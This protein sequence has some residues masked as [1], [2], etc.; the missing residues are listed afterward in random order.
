MS[1]NCTECNKCKTECQCQ[2]PSVAGPMYA[3]PINSF[4]WTGN[5]LGC[6]PNNPF[7]VSGQNLQDALTNV[8]NYVCN[9]QLI[10]GPQGAD[11]A[12]GSDAFIYTG[13]TLIVSTLGDD[14]T[15]SRE[16]W[17]KHFKTIT[18]A[19][20]AS[21][22]GDIII[23]FP[24][25][26]TSNADWIKS[27][28]AYFFYDNAVLTSFGVCI[29][30]SALQ[31][32]IRI[33]GRGSFFSQT[34]S[35]VRLDNQFTSIHFEFKYLEGYT[36]VFTIVNC[37]TFYFKG[38]MI[39]PVSQYLGTIRGECEGIIDVR[40]QD[41]SSTFLQA[42]A[43]FFTN[44][45]VSGNKK[46]VKIK[47]DILKTNS[48]SSLGSIVQYYTCGLNSTI[49]YDVRK[50]QRSIAAGQE[51]LFACYFGKMVVRNCAL[52]VDT[53]LCF[54]NGGR[55]DID[56]V[57]IRCNGAFLQTFSASTVRV[58]N[59]VG[60]SNLSDVS[61]SFII[62]QNTFMDVLDNQ[63][64]VNGSFNAFTLDVGGRFAFGGNIIFMPDGSGY[65]IAATSTPII[66]NYLKDDFSNRANDP[67]VTNAITGTALLTDPLI[68]L[69]T[70]INE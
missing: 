30:D 37:S 9:I 51:P 15:A 68:D 18:A 65:C 32:D 14:N 39:R 57:S 63:F 50:T 11:G 55:L 4:V 13:K 47:G 21:L 53:E 3:F 41:A 20:A 33:Y 31:K 35:A 69:I 29:T 43:Y 26:Y 64:T 46:V 2:R 36:D 22:A 54:I 67:N 70:P 45:A 42:I 7:V 5:S 61:N 8:I 27:G 24:G 28:V 1:N 60:S 52:D 25:N 44:H 34:S 59:C 48:A 58:T 56:N 38:D 10:T 49:V 23:V 17:G 6:D 66:V 19:T 16:N 62:A 40:H 12:D